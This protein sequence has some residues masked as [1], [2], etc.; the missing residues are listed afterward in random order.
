LRGR[1]ENITDEAKRERKAIREF[2]ISDNC[3]EGMI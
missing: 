2:N 1:H 3:E